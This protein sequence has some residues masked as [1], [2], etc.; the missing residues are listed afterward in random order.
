MDVFQG[1]VWSTVCYTISLIS[2]NILIISVGPFLY[3]I[4]SNFLLAIIGLTRYTPPASFS[5]Y[6]MTG[7]SILSMISQPIVLVIFILGISIYY[8]NMR[9]QYMFK[10]RLIIKNLVIRNLKEEFKSYK[11]IFL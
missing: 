4:I 5:P 7:T 3:A 2:N 9:N 11:W 8:K 1:V 6:L 10:N